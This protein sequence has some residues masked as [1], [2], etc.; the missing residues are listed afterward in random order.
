M[1]MQ[2]QKG[3]TCLLYSAAMVFGVPA[4]EIQEFLGHDCILLHIQEL[5]RFALTKDCVLAPFE[6]V[7]SLDEEPVDCWGALAPWLQYEGI[8]L[9]ETDKGGNHAVAWD[10]TEIF[11]PAVQP[12]FAGYHTFFAKIPNLLNK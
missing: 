4:S 11:D 1:I 2:K 9:G 7:P 8:M 10:G 12:S 5:Q 6:P 3:R